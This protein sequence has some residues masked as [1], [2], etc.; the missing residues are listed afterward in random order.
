MYQIREITEATRNEKDPDI[1][2]ESFPALGPGL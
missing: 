2:L 1:T